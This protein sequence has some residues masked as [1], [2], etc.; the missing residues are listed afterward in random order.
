LL[1]GV[2]AFAAT[3]QLAAGTNITPGQAARWLDQSMIE[4]IVFDGPDRVLSVGHHRHFTGALRRAI[5]V[6]DRTCQHPYC[7]EPAEQCQ[8]DHIEPWA[9]GGRTTQANGKLRCSFHNRHRE[10]EHI[11][12]KRSNGKRP[13]GAPPPDD[14]P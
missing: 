2:D 7:N 4:R 13:R 10:P 1:V 8:I 3:C 9:R 6:R 11:R 5:E 12:R 14:P